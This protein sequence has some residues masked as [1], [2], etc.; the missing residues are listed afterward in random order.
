MLFIHGFIVPFNG[1]IVNIKI[2]R[3]AGAGGGYVQGGNLSK[4]LDAASGSEGRTG[5]S[6]FSSSLERA[7]FCL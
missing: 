4:T 2:E 6:W 1:T 3:V 5:G 7:V